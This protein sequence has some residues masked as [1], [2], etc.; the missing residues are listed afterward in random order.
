MCLVAIRGICRFISSYLMTWVAVMAIGQ[1]R[2]DMFNK[3]LS[4]PPQYYQ[5]SSSGEILMNIVQ[6]AENSMNN[7]SN[8]FIVLTRDTLTVVGLIITL[9]YLNWQL[10]L[11]IFIM[12]PVLSLL[13]R[14]YRNRLK[15]IINSAQLT[16]GS[17]N[18]VVN[19]SHSGHRIIK[20]FDGQGRANNKFSAV[21]STIVRLGKKIAQATSA[22]SPISEFVGSTALAVVIFVAV[23]Q[24]QKGITTVGAFT[25]FIVAMMQMFG[26]IKNLANISIPMQTMF[27]AS[28]S[29]CQFL[30][31]ESETDK[32]E[33]TITRARGE[34]NYFNINVQYSSDSKNAL[35]DFNLTIKAGEKIA[36]IGRSGSG[37]TTAI[38]LLPR[39]VTPTSGYITI[40]GI[41]INELSL[42]NLR[43]QFALVTQDIFLFDDTLYENVKYGCPAAS[44][45]EIMQAIRDANLEDVVHKL[46]LGVHQPIGMNGN[47]LSGGQRQRVSIARAILKNAPILLLDEATSALDSESER[48]V[49]QAL[50]RLMTGR[51]SIIIAHRLSTIEQMDRIIVMDDG[52]IIEEGSHKELL[53]KNGYY[54]RLHNSSKTH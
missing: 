48:L 46:P 1:L 14:Y 36:L 34:L 39:F 40:D 21:N 15:D 44:D 33:K 41:N 17:L 6:M 30:D 11:L 2:Q 52:K 16:I 45:D 47:Q 3:M 23:W 53:S 37:K 29:V 50:D 26:P 49:Q 27:L 43:N 28:D 54:A 8:V 24:S 32:K 13:S 51:T 18:N 4:L 20:I 19:E 38:N 22:R 10:A 25:G 31:T 9:F 7:A 5:K 35:E 42:V 12:F